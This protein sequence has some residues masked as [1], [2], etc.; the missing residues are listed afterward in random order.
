MHRDCNF[1]YPVESQHGKVKQHKIHEEFINTR[2]EPALALL[3]L[4]P[5]AAADGGSE[6][7]LFA[8]A[9]TAR[10]VWKLPVLLEGRPRTP[11][12]PVTASSWLQLLLRR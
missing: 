9:R 5:S 2:A 1:K 12:V 11:W 8:F 10:V 6:K 7:T 3:E 4:E